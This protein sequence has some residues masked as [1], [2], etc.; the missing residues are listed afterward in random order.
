[1]VSVPFQRSRCV[2][3]AGTRATK[4]IEYRSHKLTMLRT[5]SSKSGVVYEMRSRG[6]V[7]RSVYASILLKSAHG[8]NV[9][10]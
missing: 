9:R 8:L 3:P 10:R 5:G 4:V 6:L 7:K 1:M 2:V